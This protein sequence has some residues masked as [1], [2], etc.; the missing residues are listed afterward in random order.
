[1]KI[2]ISIMYQN[3]NLLTFVRQNKTT[4]W[5]KVLLDMIV[6]L[7]YSMAKLIEYR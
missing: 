5:D 7:L 1:M 2:N 4:L 3:A 6:I